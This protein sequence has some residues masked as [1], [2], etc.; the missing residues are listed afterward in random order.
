MEHNADWNS[1]PFGHGLFSQAIL[2]PILYQS[3]LQQQEKCAYHLVADQKVTIGVKISKPETFVG[4]DEEFIAQWQ[5]GTERAEYGFS[6][7]HETSDVLH[8]TNYRSALQ[9][10]DSSNLYNKE[11]NIHG[12]MIA[13]TF[14][15]VLH[16]A[17][18]FLNTPLQLRVSVRLNQALVKPVNQRSGMNNAEKDIRA[19]MD[20][21]RYRPQAV[22]V[23]NLEVP[24]VVMYPLVVE[25]HIREVRADLSIVAVTV[26]NASQEVHIGV[27]ELSIHLDRTHTVS[28]SRNSHKSDRSTAMES[29]AST[30]S[31]TLMNTDIMLSGLP[32]DAMSSTLLLNIS[33]APLEEYSLLYSV[34]FKSGFGNSNGQDHSGFIYHAPCTL[35]WSIACASHNAPKDLRDAR[36]QEVPDRSDNVDISANGGR[37]EDDDLLHKYTCTHSELACSLSWTLGSTYSA[38]AAVVSDRPTNTLDVTVRGPTTVSVGEC[39][40]LLACIRNNGSDAVDNAILCAHSK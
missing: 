39:F 14:E 40:E 32:P 22:P 26:R 7:L 4:T 30:F 20:L 28:N 11:L 6:V 37:C 23:R 24:I 5:R 34:T 15:T 8:E 38:I 1:V 21:N 10:L 36:N 31:I 35:Y 12:N 29:P 27:H 25:S 13:V 16:V 9:T 33:I 3:A 17:K 19:L 2:T 18:Q